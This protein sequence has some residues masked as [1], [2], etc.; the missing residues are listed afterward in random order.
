MRRIVCIGNCLLARDA[1]GPLVYQALRAR[2]LPVGV[3][4]VDGGL[5]GLDLLRL[6]DGVEQVVFVDAVEGRGQPGQVLVL[7]PDA[8]ADAVGYG[9]GAGLPALLAVLPQV[10]QRPLP[11]VT[12]VGLEAPFD[13]AAVDEA[14]TLS[15]ALLGRPPT[16]SLNE[17][18]CA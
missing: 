16:R 7:G 3:E 8:L 4:L 15:L 1:A 9:H 12:L 11:Q 10:C 6:V 14:A 13:A 5:A 17:E 18:T 2:E